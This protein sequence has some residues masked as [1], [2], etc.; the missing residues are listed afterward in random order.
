[1]SKSVLYVEDEENDIFFVRLAFRRAGLTASLHVATD[2]REAVDFLSASDRERFPLPS[3]VLLDLNLPVMSGWDVLRWI[4]AQPP[5]K[6]LPV[7]VLSSS[8]QPADRKQAQ[9]LHA[10]DYIV[11]PANMSEMDEVMRRL[12]GSWLGEMR[13]K[14]TP[15]TARNR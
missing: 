5:L 15:V 9:E 6:D 10:D 8:I 3:L 14:P 12:K 4:R 7:V 13:P 11:K 2:G 1:M